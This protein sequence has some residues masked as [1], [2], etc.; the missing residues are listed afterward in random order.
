MTELVNIY[1]DASCHL[2]HDQQRVM[3]LGAI[4]MPAE[5]DHFLA[6]DQLQK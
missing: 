3:V 6:S 1:C 4:W 2:E 5:D